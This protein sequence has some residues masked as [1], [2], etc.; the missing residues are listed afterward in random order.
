M[1]QFVG[2]KSDI[3]TVAHKAMD[4]LLLER[5]DITPMHKHYFISMVSRGIEAKLEEFEHVCI[6]EKE[7]TDM[8]EVSFDMS[9][10]IADSGGLVYTKQ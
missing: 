7:L 8:V 6:A 2:T 3:V 1:A 5:H 4:E 9:K 10:T